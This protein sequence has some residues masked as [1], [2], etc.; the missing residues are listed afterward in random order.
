MSLRQEHLALLEKALSSIEVLNSE[1][2]QPEVCIQ[3][4]VK[5]TSQVWNESAPYLMGNIRKQ[6]RIN[7]VSL[8]GLEQA[9]RRQEFLKK[10]D[11]RVLANIKT[12]LSQI[13]QIIKSAPSS[14]Q[15]KNPISNYSPLGMRFG[16]LSELSDAKPFVVVPHNL[17]SKGNITLES[18]V[19]E[20]SATPFADDA[21]IFKKL[22][23]MQGFKERLPNK[24]GSAGFVTVR[25]PILATMKILDSKKLG[26]TGLDYTILPGSFL[27]KNP[28]VMGEQSLRDMPTVLFYNQLLVG[29]SNE[30]SKDSNLVEP[31]VK[32]VSDRF[33]KQVN[34]LESPSKDVFIKSSG[35]S[36]SWIWLMPERV[37]AQSFMKLNTA[38]FPWLSKENPVAKKERNEDEKRELRWLEE[39]QQILLKQGKSLNLND[40]TRI[41]ELREQQSEYKPEET[42][43]EKTKR[44]ADQKQ[45]LQKRIEKRFAKEL[46]QIKLIKE[47]IED[48]SEK[49]D[50]ESKAKIRAKQQAIKTIELKIEKAKPDIIKDI[51]S[52]IK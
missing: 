37:F 36:L 25:M 3:E 47:E 6:L 22:Q 49:D 23:E 13:G 40:L 26:R 44:L 51:K 8:R 46:I 27:F 7:I 16:S 52:K 32:M 12:Q 28:L 20:T 45:E 19:A 41:S 35:N 18:T 48:L 11:L 9:A 39:Q 24:V 15:R 5:D 38:S 4:A 2:T 1:S 10:E 33:G 21:T 30:T 14:S 42:F 34:I 29:V 43:E 17:H 31:I 50:K